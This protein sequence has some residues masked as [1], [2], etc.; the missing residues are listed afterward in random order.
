M[1][2]LLL[3]QCFWPDIVATA[4]QLTDAA[5]GLAERGH[6]VRVIASR[7]GYDDPRLRFPQ[8]ERWKEIEIV[9]LRSISL[10]KARAWKRAL[11]F[12]SFTLAC[13]L[14]LAVTRRHDAV[15]VLT[16]PPL[17]SWLASMFTRIKGGHLIFWVM[18]LNPDEAIAAGW[19]KADSVAA[20]LLNTLLKSSLSRADRIVVLDRFMKD[21]I[22]AKG[23]PEEKIAIIP[24]CSDDSIHYDKPGREEFRTAH[25]LSGKFVVMHAGN[26][27]P[28]HSLDTLLESASKLKERNDIVFC[29]VGGGS[30]LGKVRSY[31]RAQQL[32]NI[33]CLPYQPQAKLAGL[34]SA[35]DLHV[36]VMGEA[37]RGIVHPSKIYN[38]LATGLAFLYIGPDESHMG[39]IIARIANNGLAMH[40]TRG[41]VSLV[42]R[43]ILNS[44]D[45]VRSEAAPERTILAQ[46]FSRST[47]LPRLIAEIESPG[48]EGRTDF[49]LCAPSGVGTSAGNQV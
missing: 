45:K 24:P 42:V 15:V 19:L 7:H 18:D 14:R 17:I 23:I 38:I 39:D 44:A 20:K 27:S 33:Y 31:A 12:A 26:H 37:F 21:R 29:F 1:K 28:C 8:R 11:N 40:A 32:E 16:S 5:R 47:L 3:N 10:G 4:Q 9:R 41:D 2:I 35:A 25:N 43:Q 30:E 46:D 48:L 6:E 22:V 34:L 49:S 13:G 36:V